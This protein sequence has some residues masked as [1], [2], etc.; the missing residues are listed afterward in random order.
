[1]LH[2]EKTKENEKI[3][4]FK[5]QIEPGRTNRY[6]NVTTVNSCLEIASDVLKRGKYRLRKIRDQL[7][8][9]ESPAERVSKIG[10]SSEFWSTED[11]PVTMIKSE[12]QGATARDTV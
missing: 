6:S 10:S 4:I 1:M 3:C 11:Q 7:T 8:S 2:L 5:F 12:S 9:H